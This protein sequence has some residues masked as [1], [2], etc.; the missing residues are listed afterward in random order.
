LAELT[1]PSRLDQLGIASA[2]LAGLCAD[3]G[4]PAETRYRLD[5][6]LNEAVTNVVSYAYPDDAEHEIR[7]CL[8][9]GGEGVTLQIEDDGLPFDPLSA[10]RPALPDRLEDAKIGGLG[11]H[12]IRSLLD[13]CH[14]RRESGRNLFTML[15]RPRETEAP[16]R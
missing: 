4:L 10:G 9:A 11:I 14:Y 1:I 15:A 5:L 2:W 16:R 12:L 3:L 8:R 13:E 7:L 6:G